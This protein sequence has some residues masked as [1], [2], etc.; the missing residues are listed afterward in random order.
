M[1]L[2][3]AFYP[4]ADSPRISL[5]CLNAFYVHVGSAERLFRLMKVSQKVPRGQLGAFQD[6]FD[7]VPLKHKV[8][9]DAGLD[10]FDVVLLE[11]KVD[12]E[13]DLDVFIVIPLT[14]T[15]AF[16][17]SDHI[18]TSPRIQKYHW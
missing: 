3:T 18:G 11:H 8:N 10:V 15:A 5:P 17:V 6:V 12:L 1:V 13:A 2:L 4:R 14:I 7:V 16:N 9:L